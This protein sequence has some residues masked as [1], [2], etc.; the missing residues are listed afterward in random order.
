VTYIRLETLAEARYFAV[1]GVPVQYQLGS[2]LD[3]DDLC[4][5]DLF[6]DMLNTLVELV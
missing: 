6:D 3:S 4:G 5:Y 2:V 1:L